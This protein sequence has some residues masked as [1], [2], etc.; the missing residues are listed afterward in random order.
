VARFEL[1]KDHVLIER[2][3]NIFCSKISYDIPSTYFKKGECYALIEDEKVITSE[4][5]VNKIRIVG[6]FCLVHDLP[7]K[8]RSIKQIPED[9]LHL[10][11]RDLPT[12]KTAEFTGYFLNDKKYGLLFTSHLVKTCLLHKASRFV[13]SYPISQTGLEKYYSKGKPGRLYSG[14]PAKLQGHKDGM[15]DEN[16]E[17][18]TRWGIIKIFLARTLRYI[19]KK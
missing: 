17:V 3:K 5:T 18:L 7:W 2:F 15:E 10:A 14:Q 1:L 11:T 4:G 13:Y 8:L 6:G 16:I 12:L 9:M 19:L